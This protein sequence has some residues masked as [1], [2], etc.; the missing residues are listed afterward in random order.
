M[1][2]THESVYRDIDAE[3][4]FV[5]RDER[6][7]RVGVVG[8][9]TRRMDMLFPE[10][11]LQYII[12]M[13]S[14]ESAMAALCGAAA[15]HIRMLGMDSDVP[16]RAYAEIKVGDEEALRVLEALGFSNTDG[17]MRMHRRVSGEEN[18]HLMPRGCTIVRDFLNDPIE[19][20]LFLERYNCMYGL[21]NDESWLEEIISQ[22]DFARILM[23]SPEDLCGELLVWTEDGEGV[24]GMIQ[25]A[26]RWQRKGVASY[27]MEDARLYFRSLGLT[28]S[29]MDVWMKAPGAMKLA[30]A[31]GYAGEEPILLYPEMYL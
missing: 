30:R 20:K 11:P 2:L 28:H 19:R 29:R 4:T 5:A 22:Q 15:A 7:R 21:D 14:D 10:R 23:V 25:T 9:S 3:N 18:Y 24:I 31:A 17:V 16:A 27:L 13:D 12:R 1:R 26:R 6:R 8:I